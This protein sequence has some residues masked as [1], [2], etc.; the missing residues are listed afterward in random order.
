MLK[1][2]FSLI[3]KFKP[4]IIRFL[5]KIEQL[6][7]SYVQKTKI[8]TEKQKLLLP[9]WLLVVVFLLVF[10]LIYFVKYP[11]IIVSSVFYIIIKI[12]SILLLTYLTWISVKHFVKKLKTPYL[13]NLEEYKERVVIFWLIAILNFTLAYL[14]KTLDIF[15]FYSI[16]V[17]GFVLLVTLLI[18]EF[19]GGIYALLISLVIAWLFN[20]KYEKYEIFIFYF[21]SSLFV[22]YQA[23]KIF[24]RKDVVAVIFKSTLVNILIATT[25]FFV[26]RHNTEIDT[27]VFN[28]NYYLSPLDG[29]VLKILRDNFFGGIVAWVVVTIFLHPIETVCNRTT[30]IKL[31]ELSNFNH[32]LLNRMIT[33][34]PG[35]YHHSLFVSSLAEHAARELGANWLLCKVASYYHD[36]GKLIKPEYFIENQIA[37]PNPHTELN[38]SLS[39]LII[40]N[41]V[42]EGVLLAKKYNLDKCI[43]DIIQQHHGDSLIHGF[44]EK[45]LQLGISGLGESMRYPG[46]KPQTKE[47]VIIMI[48]DSCEAAFR[49]ISEPDIQKIKETVENVINT[50]FVEG[51]FDE[52]PV[53]LRDLYKLANIMTQVLLSLYHLR[54]TSQNEK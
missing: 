53:T 44:Y 17:F 21:L 31:V 45:T 23:K 43:I 29:I 46:P 28:L 7:S 42:K 2:L 22:T 30:N 10:V 50:K 36:I 54:T 4:A 6:E 18:D 13:N 35:T 41:H 49:S 39:G 33:E 15:Y 52:S 26:L 47:A 27:G 24:S 1:K 25:L 51:Q 16:P 8:R 20:G 34:T 9:E 12:L 32:P 48:S 14:L 3:T 11:V 5:D 19:W 40:I 38:P 37:I